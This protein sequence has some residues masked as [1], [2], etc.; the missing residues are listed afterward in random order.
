MNFSCGAYSNNITEREECFMKKML[1]GIGIV[2]L[3]LIFPFHYMNFNTNIM[4]TNKVAYDRTL[5]SIANECTVSQQFVPQ[6]N[7]IKK[8]DICVREINCNLSQGY[9]Q[10]RILDSEKNVIYQG[11]LPLTELASVG[12]RTIFNDIELVAGKTYYLNIDTVDALDGG[13]GLSFYTAF[14]AA[15]EEEKGQVLTHAGTPVGNGALKV[16]FEYLKPLYRFEYLAYYLFAIFIVS[17][18]VTKMN[19]IRKG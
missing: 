16:S 2:I 5:S 9:L 17:F 13:P 10:S 14:N 18:L 8:L 1:I 7:Y 15:S 3:F 11:E 12:W 4:S 19:K 6:Y